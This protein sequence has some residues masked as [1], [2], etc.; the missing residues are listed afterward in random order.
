VSS[1]LHPRVESGR[2]NRAY[3]LSA[4]MLIPCCFGDLAGIV[5][6]SVGEDADGGSGPT[7]ALMRP[8]SV[9]NAPGGPAI[10]T[11]KS[12]NVFRFSLKKCANQG[13]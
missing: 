5:G 2:Q 3:P 13:P 4:R 6:A 11:G 1:P 10:A 9:L 12:A 7:W 8:V